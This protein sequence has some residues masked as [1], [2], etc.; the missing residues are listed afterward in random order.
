MY[1]DTLFVITGDHSERF[2][3]AK[4]QDTRTL[5]SIPCIFMVPVCSKHGLMI[6]LLVTT[7]SW[8][9]LWQRLLDLLVLLMLHCNQICLKIK[10]WCLITGFMLQMAKFIRRVLILIKNY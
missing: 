2:S 9:E 4:E 7:C 1:S 8:Q 10:M 3:F 5:S 6:N